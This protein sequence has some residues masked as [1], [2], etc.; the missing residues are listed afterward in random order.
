MAH[1][2]K[3]FTVFLAATA[4]VGCSNKP[5]PMMSLSDAQND[6]QAAF[7]YTLM[8]NVKAARYQ[9]AQGIQ[10]DPNAVAPVYTLAYL[11]EATGHYKLAEKDF[12]K[13]IALKPNSGPAHNNYGTFL[14]HQNRVKEAVA[15]FN[16]AVSAPQYYDTDTAYENAGLCLMKDGSLA[17]AK[18]Y[19]QSAVNVNPNLKHSL[20]ELA[21]INYMEK[22]Y[23]DSSQYLKQYLQATDTPDP[24]ALKLQASLRSHHPLALTSILPAPT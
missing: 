7:Q 21:L 5:T 10:A 9:I 8:G 20:F 22:Q 24:F 12:K 6:A 19:F 15:Q 18:Q 3:L 4:L 16:L 1:Y 11:E 2:K 13:A 23:G 14:C 17:Q